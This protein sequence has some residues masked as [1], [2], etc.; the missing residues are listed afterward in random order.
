MF[1]FRVENHD[2]GIR[3]GDDCAFFGEQAEH[4]RGSDIFVLA[5]SS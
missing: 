4:F 1:L 2:V 5:D 3:A